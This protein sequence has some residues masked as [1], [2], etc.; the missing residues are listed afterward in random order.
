MNNNYCELKLTL[1]AHLIKLQREAKSES[2]D[3]D[4]K[5]ACFRHFEGPEFR[6]GLLR[7]LDTPEAKEFF[8]QAILAIKKVDPQYTRPYRG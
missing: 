8:F 2:E 1:M 5:A 3:A 6:Q 7:L 4:F